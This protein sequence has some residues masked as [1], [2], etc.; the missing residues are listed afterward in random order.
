MAPHRWANE[1]QLLFLRSE[2]NEFLEKQKEK[3]LALFWPALHH[4]WFSRWPVEP[5]NPDTPVPVDK[6]ELDSYQEEERALI[7]KQKDV[8]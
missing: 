6:E 7:T 3:K 2:L 4:E 1:E 5:N 8:R